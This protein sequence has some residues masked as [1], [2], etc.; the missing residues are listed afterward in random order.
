MSLSAANILVLLVFAFVARRAWI[1]FAVRRGLPLPPGPKGWPIIGNLYDIPKDRPYEV[2]AR[3]SEKYQSDVIY[4][5]VAGTSLVILNS[6]EATNDLFVGRSQLYSD[7]PELTMKDLIGLELSVVFARYGEQWRKQRLLFLQEVSPANL[8]M[9]HK[10]RMQESTSLLLSSLLDTP[11]DVDNHIHLLYGGTILSLAYGISNKDPN[12][13]G[14]YLEACKDAMRAVSE[15][16]T[17]GK[18]VVDSIPALQHLPGWLPGMGFKK[19]AA[20]KRT[21]VRRM[22]AAPMAFAKKKLEKGAIKSSMASRQL[23]EMQDDGSWSEEK[24][25]MLTEQFQTTRSLILAFLLRPEIQKKGQIAVDEVVGSDRLP[26]FTDEGKIPYVDALVMEILRWKPVAP[27]AVAHNTASADIYKGYYIPANTVVIGNSWALLHNPALYGE[28]V[29]Q[30]RPERFLNADGTLNDKV[31]YP[32]AA[33]GYGRRTCAGKSVAQS[34]LWLTVA[35]LLACFDFT[36][37]RNSKGEEIWPT[38]DY[39]DGIISSPK[40]Y[41]CVIRPRSE[42]VKALIRHRREQEELD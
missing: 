17:F 15:V 12:E 35:S 18:Y 25:L 23:Q 13:Y 41:P 27:M 36:K 5:N 40:P 30:F 29:D 38:T 28:D 3:M 11:E 14:Y 33:F 1:H 26:D 21:F 32:S 6:A 16:T 34:A 20:H 8:E 10:P 42:T 4:L 9:Y 2:Y 37:A 22:I 7:R 31:P 39:D 19:D 24:E